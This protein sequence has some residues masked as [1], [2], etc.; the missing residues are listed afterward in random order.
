MK[1]LQLTRERVEK[2]KKGSP[3]S[4]PVNLRHNEKKMNNNYTPI[5]A[6]IHTSS[7]SKGAGVISPLVFEPSKSSRTFKSQRS[8]FMKTLQSITDFAEKIKKKEKRKSSA[9]KE[10]VGDFHV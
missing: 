2:A 5:C 10:V 8:S 1:N 6:L 3:S 9:E 4:P 7:P